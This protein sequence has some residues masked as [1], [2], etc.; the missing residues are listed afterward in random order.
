M[1]STVLRPVLV[2]SLPLVSRAAVGSTTPAAAEDI[3]NVPAD[4][5][6]GGFDKGLLGLLGLAGLLGLKRRND[7][8][9][10]HSNA[11]RN[12]ATRSTTRV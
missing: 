11:E 10:R 12:D 6:D 3:Q 9:A 4:R 8:D 5:H 1:R 2:G 7:R